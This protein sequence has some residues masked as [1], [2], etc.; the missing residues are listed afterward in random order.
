MSRKA[1]RSQEDSVPK[2][3]H[4]QQGRQTLW[5]LGADLLALSIYPYLV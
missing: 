2:T 4:E 3:P 5:N 1:L